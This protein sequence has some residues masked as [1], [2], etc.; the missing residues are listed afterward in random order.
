MHRYWRLLHSF[1]PHTFCLQEL[2]FLIVCWL[3]FIRWTDHYSLSEYHVAWF[4]CHLWLMGMCLFR[5]GH[6]CS[7]SL[8]HAD[9]KEYGA[10]LRW[11]AVPPAKLCG[12]CPQERGFPETRGTCIFSW[13]CWVPPAYFEK[14]KSTSCFPT[15]MC[16]VSE[17]ELPGPNDWSQKCSCPL[18]ILSL[19]WVLSSMPMSVLYRGAQNWT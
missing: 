6:W 12:I 14:L 2:L 15:D 8:G 7:C 19:H 5:S 11:V 18:I 9:A 3:P 1:L 4:W 16:P 17:L 13:C 10:H